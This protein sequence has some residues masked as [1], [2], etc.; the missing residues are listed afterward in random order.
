MVQHF[1]TLPE[2]GRL[3]LKVCTILKSAKTVQKHG[4]ANIKR[5]WGPLLEPSENL[6]AVRRFPT[7]HQ[8]CLQ[9]AVDGIFEPQQS[10]LLHECKWVFLHKSWA[11]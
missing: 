7:A 3:G 2:I 6:Q 4:P 1:Q 10:A 8:A 5:S 11:V 9:H